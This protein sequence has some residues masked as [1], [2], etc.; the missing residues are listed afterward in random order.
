MAMI[1]IAIIVLGLVSMTMLGLDLL[2][3][4]EIPAVSVL[5][6]YEGAGPEEV[7]DGIIL[8]IEENL[9]SLTGIKEVKSLAAEGA[10]IVTVEVLQG[11]LKGVRA[12]RASTGLVEN[13]SVEYY[14]NP[15]PFFQY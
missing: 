5:T 6:A 2:P 11:E 8:K 4:L 7:E 15:T 10:G 3:D 13:L 14:G 9:S 1:F 12:G